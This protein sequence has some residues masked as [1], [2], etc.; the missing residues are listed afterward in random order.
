MSNDTKSIQVLALGLMGLMV[1]IGLTFIVG[2]QYLET[3][4]TDIDSGTWSA[5]G[6]SCSVESDAFNETENVIDAIKLITAFLT[7]IVLVLI[8]KVLVQNARSVSGGE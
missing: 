3:I 6:S 5:G 4:C 8:V 1:V 7:V 2:D